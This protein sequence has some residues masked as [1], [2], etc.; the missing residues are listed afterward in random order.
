[1]DPKNVLDDGRLSIEVGDGVSRRT[2]LK[3][4]AAASALVGSAGCLSRR[5]DPGPTDDPD[6]ETPTETDETTTPDPTAT[7]PTD[8]DSPAAGFEFS[9][10][11]AV[12]PPGWEAS[13]TVS[14]DGLSERRAVFVIQNIDNPFFI[15]LTAGFHDALNTFGWTGT[16]KGPG[17]DGVLQDQVR[18]IE[19]TAENLSAGDVLV[20]TIL[21]TSLYNDAIQTALDN[22]IA[23]VN[24]HTTPATNRPG[25]GT[26][27]AWTYGAQ[28]DEFTY[29]S[30]VTGEERGMI[31]PHVGIRDARGGAAMA[32]EMYERLQAESPAQDEYTVFLVND[33]PDNPTVTRRV[34]KNLATEGTAQR[35]FEAQDDVTIYG[36]QV[37]TTPQP[38]EIAASRNFIVD[39]IQDEDVD[40]VVGSAFWSAVG[41]GGAVEAGELDEDMLVCA[42]DVAGM[43]GDDAGPIASG[44]V[45]FVV[46]QDMYGQGYRSAE[47]AWT[48]LE[49][50][51]PMKDLE[52]GVS[53]WDERNIEFATQ[54]RSWED[55]LEWQNNN[56]DGI[57]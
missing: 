15:P 9:R 10:H 48:W 19:E 34:D 30:P 4:V 14:G 1:M 42:F 49:R 57:G 23:V 53:V 24:G 18:I 29:T 43:T 2:V 21:N 31:I 41:A 7:P 32:A 35:Y 47:A 39:R 54:R 56:Y 50:G 22:D 5:S 6:P 20:T 38:P 16:V 25:Q 37:F 44:G 55:L 52:W 33:L 36:D 46:G 51:I 11:P 8:D 40:A 3:Q 17:H 12:A 13:N 28:M 27:N 26:D 45:D